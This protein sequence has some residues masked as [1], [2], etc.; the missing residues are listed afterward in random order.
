ML[1]VALSCSA[2]HGDVAQT[3]YVTNTSGKAITA[4][5]KIMWK[6]NGVNGSFVLQ[7]TLGIGQ[8]VSD[9]AN[10]GNGGAC[11]ASYFA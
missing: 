9:L 6:L 5:T 11:T 7:Q 10:P 8:M 4:G 2:G 1:T 3:I